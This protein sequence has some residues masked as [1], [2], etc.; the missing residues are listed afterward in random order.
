MKRFIKIAILLLIFVCVGIVGYNVLFF[1]NEKSVSL[2]E[3]DSNVKI[4]LECRI[5]YSSP[6]YCNFISDN[7]ME[8]LLNIVQ[9]KYS[10]GF[11]DEK[12]DAIYLIESNSIY[13]V[14]QY[15]EKSFFGLNRYYYVFAKDEIL[16]Q[17][18]DNEDEIEDVYI[19][20]PN[21][22]LK[23]E[24]IGPNT[25]YEVGCEIE[26]IIKFY[27]SMDNCDVSELEILIRLKGN[28]YVMTID[29]KT[30][31]INITSSK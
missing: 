23:G 4:D 18:E 3:E 16:V 22:A 24:Y 9:N 26:D 29:E 27:S 14:K 30:L 15:K 12:L 31:N 25:E 13:S 8:E 17:S 2:W 21:N 19:P 11:Y 10:N 7:S 28:E 1:Y 6:K 20:F 5:I